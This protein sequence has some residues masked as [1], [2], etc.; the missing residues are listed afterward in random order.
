[1]FPAVVF[2][3]YAP[4]N[5]AETGVMIKSMS[6]RS[7]ESL[8]IALLADIH[9]NDIALQA[10]FSDIEKKGGVDRFW[11]LGDV[12][13]IGHAPIS[14]LSLLHAQ[15]NLQ[16]LSGNTE[17][18]ICTG[19][20]PPPSI[21]DVEADPTLLPIMLNVEGSFS[22]TQG[23][24]SGSEHLVWM[25]NLPSE[26]EYRLPDS[27]SLIC[28]HGSPSGGDFAGIWPGMEDDEIELLLSGYEHDIVCVGHTHWP[29]DVRINGRHI[30]NPG[31]VS[32]PI[33]CD[34]RASYAMFTADNRGYNVEFHRVDYDLD[35]VIKILQDIRH[36]A[37]DFITQHL[38][39]EI[40]PEELEGIS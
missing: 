35:A 29:L 30:I 3:R 19:D 7:E 31:S 33:G 25:S 23:V 28:V 12:A 6:V 38:R 5:T 16:C 37:C 18:Y 36:P 1:M 39:G 2:R 11:V 21:E 26:I 20:R 40:I 32:N 8:R 13:A 34:T 17:R 4:Q 27:T 10:V 14:V 15:D 9:G 24:L 22:W